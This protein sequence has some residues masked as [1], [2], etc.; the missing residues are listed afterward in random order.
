MQGEEQRY[1]KKKKSSEV[2][3]ELLYSPSGLILTRKTNHQENP[4]SQGPT[5]KQEEEMEKQILKILRVQEIEQTGTFLQLK[6]P[7]F[8]T[9]FCEKMRKTCVS[10]LMDIAQQEKLSLLT[11]HL[12]VSYIDRIS[13]FLV[14]PEP[15]LFCLTCLFVA[16]KVFFRTKY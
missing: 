9:K 4:V 3:H 5:Q 7:R 2:N 13:S 8:T 11:L 15:S 16:G 1:T 12:A 14:L 10:W 6:L